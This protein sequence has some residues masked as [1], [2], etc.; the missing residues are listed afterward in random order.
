MAE[1]D[2]TKWDARYLE[3]PPSLEPSPW[4]GEWWKHADEN[5]LP[6]SGRVLDVAGG[7]GRHSIWFAQR[8]FDVTLVDVSSVAV[9]LAEKRAQEAGVN[10]KTLVMDLEKEA[11]PDG[12][13]DIILQMHYLDRDL[14]TQYERILGV[15]GLLIIEHPTR[16]N[17]FRH[18]K[19]GPN[20]LLEDGELPD[21]LHEFVL[22]SYGEG[23]NEAGRHEA[24][25]VARKV[26]WA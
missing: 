6:K 23:W 25:L 7:G 24:R 2:R 21:L 3:D 11:L 26:K 5:M 18:A 15:T 14:I 4:L 9:G 16:A 22:I 8:G 20:Y 17:L 12:P 13:W 19:P 1:A 10:L